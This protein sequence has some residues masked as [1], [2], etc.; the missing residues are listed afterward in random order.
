MGFKRQPKEVIEGSANIANGRKKAMGF[1]HSNGAR[2]IVMKKPEGNAYREAV[3]IFVLGHEMGHIVAWE[4]WGDLSP[5]QQ[6]RLKKQFDKERQKKT[7]GNYTYTDDQAGFEEWFADQVSAWAKKQSEK[8]SNYNEAFFKGVVTK[9][10]EIWRNSKLF[11]KQQL[12]SGNVSNR[13]RAQ[14]RDMK[15]RATLNETFEQL[16]MVL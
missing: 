8:P 12:D 5:A 7:A 15:E 6:A 14:L 3:Q 1:T 13:G 11:V 2:Y 9:M 10:R 16:W 4:M